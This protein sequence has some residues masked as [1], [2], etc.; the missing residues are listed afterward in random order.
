MPAAT[1]PHGPLQSPAFM[2]GRYSTSP[3]KLHPTSLQ[4][5]FI[6]STNCIPLLHPGEITTVGWLSHRTGGC[7]MEW[8]PRPFRALIGN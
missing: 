1:S 3:H 4:T 6:S 8:P 2:P 5:A 7:G